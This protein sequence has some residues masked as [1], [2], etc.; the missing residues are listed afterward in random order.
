MY[1]LYK[2]TIK[3]LRK[4]RFPINSNQY[5]AIVSNAIALSIGNRL[6]KNRCQAWV[7]E[8]ADEAASDMKSRGLCSIYRTALSVS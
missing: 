4:N 8:A 3:V 1:L 5:L 2:F 6:V 7:G